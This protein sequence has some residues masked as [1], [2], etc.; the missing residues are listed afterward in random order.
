ML[1]LTQLVCSR[2]KTYF[3]FCVI[4]PD[5]TSFKNDPENSMKNAKYEIPNADNS[6]PPPPLSPNIILSEFFS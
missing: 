1:A 3:L 4:L 5:L 2:P 6:G